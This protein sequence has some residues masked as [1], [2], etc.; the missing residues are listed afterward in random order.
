V[1]LDAGTWNLGL[2][3]YTEYGQ[4]IDNTPA[5]I[6]VSSGQ[7]I[8]HNLTVAYEIPAAAGTVDLKGAP[9]DFNSKAY[10]G[11]QGCPSGATKCKGGTESYEDIGPGQPYSIDLSPGSWT[12]Y[13]YYRQYRTN[14]TFNGKRVTITAVSG[15]TVQVNLPIAFQGL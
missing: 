15:Q 9:K 4:L 11:V 3:Y 12:I 1:K 10:M 7:R 14:K 6:T 5:T 2:Y 8:I 13:A